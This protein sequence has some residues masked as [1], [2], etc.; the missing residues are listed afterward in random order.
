MSTQEKI[1]SLLDQAVKMHQ[2]NR[3]KEAENLYKKVLTLSPRQYDALNLLGVLAHQSGN[4]DQAI[5]LFDQAIAASPNLASAHFN[6]GNVLYGNKQLEE[7]VSCYKTALTY[8][9]QSQDA[10]LNLGVILQEQEKTGEALS[11]FLK[12]I[13]IAPNNPKA[14]YNAGK[15]LH[16]TGNL[17]DAEK[18]L[19]DALKLDPENADCC[20]ALATVKEELHQNEEAIKYIQKAIKIKPDWAQ[21]YLIQIR[22]LKKTDSNEQALVTA[23]NAVK[24]S[25]RSPLSLICLA[26]AQG[27]NFEHLI[28]EIHNNNQLD[29]NELIA[30]SNIARDTIGSW[31]AIR[32]LNQS[33]SIQETEVALNNLGANFDDLSLFSSARVCYEL[34]VRLNRDYLKTL[35]SYGCAL[36]RNTQL[37]EGWDILSERIYNK[38]FSNLRPGNTPIWKGE[39]ISK[40]TLYV[41]FEEGLGEHILQASMIGSIIPS[42]K[43]CIVECA[44]RLVPIIK[45]SYPNAQVISGT[46]K[47]DVLDALKEADYQIPGINLGSHT[48][49]DLKSFS[50]KQ[51][52]FLSA[53]KEISDKFRN[54]YKAMANG[55]RIIG[56][57]WISGSSNH[58]KYKSI[59]LNELLP[60][61]EKQDVFPVSLQYGP[62]SEELKK[63]AIKTGHEIYFDD[64]FDQIKD[65]EQFFGQINAMDLVVSISGTTVHAAGSLGVPTWLMIPSGR[66]ALWYWFTKG[67]HSPWYPSVR[68]FRETSP[69][70]TGTPWWPTVIDNV[71]KELSVWLKK[72]LEPRIDS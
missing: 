56:V 3:L 64:S 17:K 13:K 11:I 16:A 58:G 25:N 15:C 5:D 60:I 9:P 10:L 43:K 24:N 72:P 36:L 40:K 23:N 1:I 51:S 69:P 29:H 34:A 70:D 59:D 8:D 42:A 22:I 47:K 6:K 18:S 45:R 44:K 12:L 62:V 30:L 38:N 52:G 4:N 50:Q 48:R 26:W 54:K 31:P 19:K 28:E 41:F 46:E 39:D 35:K 7:S 27:N 21:A 20:F 2:A 49:R 33:I 65:L 67:T 66:G 32:L 37:E 14:H 68:L 61:I 53:N 71:D 55:K 63:F 57:N